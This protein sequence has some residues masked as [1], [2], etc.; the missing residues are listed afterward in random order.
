MTRLTAKANP[1]MLLRSKLTAR[2]RRRFLSKHFCSHCESTYQ[3]II[4]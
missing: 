2:R 4:I 1:A 3:G